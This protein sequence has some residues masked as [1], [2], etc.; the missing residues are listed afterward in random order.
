MDKV[1]VVVG[2]IVIVV[3]ALLYYALT[4]IEKVVYSKQEEEE[5]PSYTKSSIVFYNITYTIKA[6]YLVVNR[7]KITMKDYVYIA[8]PRNTTYQ[9]SRLVSM[10]PKPIKI[11]KDDDGNVFAVVIVEAKPGEKIW[12]EAVYSVR[13][14]GYKIFFNVNE[15]LWPEYP[16]VRKLTSKTNFW[17]TENE[18][19]INL[20]YRIKKGDTPLE[21]A[22]SVAKWVRRHMSYQV[23]GYRLGSDRALVRTFMGDYI[24]QGDCTEI[25]DVYVTLMR[26]L[27]VPA[28]TVFGILLTEHKSKLWINMTTAHR[29]GIELIKHWGGHMWSQV[30]LPPW[31]WVDVEMLEELRVKLG[32]YS[33]YHIIFGIEETKYYGTS[34]GG[35]CI[36]SYLYL[37]Y[38]EMKF[39]PSG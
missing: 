20:A 7:Y 28:R 5:L 27:G 3:G 2:L 14:S 6:K 31:G 39:E 38:I 12:I 11:D 35:F 25:A 34:L 33:N 37:E 10:N 13:V 23:I 18:E 32:E 29:E 24:I 16:V 9:Y 4:E 21:V 30:Y 19:I 36:P 1:V 22:L 17:N 8:L 15:S 26:I